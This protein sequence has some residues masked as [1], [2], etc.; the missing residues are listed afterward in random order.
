MSLQGSRTRCQCFGILREAGEHRPEAI[1][2][3]G[4]D[5]D[6][7][8]PPGFPQA[9]AT[10]CDDGCTARHCLEC[11]WSRPRARRPYLMQCSPVGGSDPSVTQ[12]GPLGRLRATSTPPAAKSQYPRNG[13]L[14]T[15]PAA[16]PP[17]YY[18]S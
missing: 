3:V 15:P 5:V 7:R 12:R 4:I 16:P 1:G 17:G 9:A 6:R 13:G 14:S 2:I 18:Y 11:D 8:S 10:G